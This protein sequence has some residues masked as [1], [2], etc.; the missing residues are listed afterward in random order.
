MC[1]LLHVHSFSVSFPNLSLLSFS[2]QC[3]LA[4]KLKLRNTEGFRGEI[5]KTDLEEKISKDGLREKTE[6]ERID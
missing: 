6:L 3:I 5:V 2:S 1:L 4:E